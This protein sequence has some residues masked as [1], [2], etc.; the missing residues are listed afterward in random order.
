MVDAGKKVHDAFDQ[1][2]KG[3]TR[4]NVEP[5]QPSSN[6]LIE[7]WRF[8]DR[9]ARVSIGLM[10]PDF[11]SNEWLG[12]FLSR[13]GSAKKVEGIGDAAASWGYADTVITFLHGRFNVSVSGTA[14]F[15]MLTLD[16]RANAAMANSES[17]AT[18]RLIAC[19]VN[20]ALNGDLQRKKHIPGDGFLRRPCEQELLRRGFL[21]ADLL[22]QW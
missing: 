3:W 15:N 22:N 8:C 10:R 2:L 11:K 20:M 13:D 1:N 18:S 9:G 21:N 4:E 5:M 12:E 6:V 14:F 7:N 17:A 19:F 16:Q